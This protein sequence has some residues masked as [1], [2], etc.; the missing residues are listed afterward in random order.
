MGGTNLLHFEHSMGYQGSL[1]FVQC[2]RFTLK[3]AQKTSHAL[4]E[5]NTGCSNVVGITLS[6]FTKIFTGKKGCIMMSAL[7][8]VTSYLQLDIVGLDLTN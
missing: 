7:S 6:V 8:G 2:H 1:W 5:W 3:Q 4:L